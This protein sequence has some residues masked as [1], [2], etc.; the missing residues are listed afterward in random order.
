VGFAK[1]LLLQLAKIMIV[2]V[3]P[4]LDLSFGKSS[5][6]FPKFFIGC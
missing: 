1:A 3:K 6:N 5:R 2:S 4:V